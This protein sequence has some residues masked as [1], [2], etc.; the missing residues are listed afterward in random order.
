MDLL[1][2]EASGNA[3][4]EEQKFQQQLTALKE[5]LQLQID[6]EKQRFTELAD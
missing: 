5:S 3:K 2:E 4:L 1:R 6:A